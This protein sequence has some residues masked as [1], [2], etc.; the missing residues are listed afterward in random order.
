MPSMTDAACLPEP[1]CDVL[2]TTLSPRLLLP[3]AREGRVVF[4]VE[5]AC[6]VVGDVEQR[7]VLGKDRGRGRGEQQG[8]RS[9]ME[10]A[11]SAHVKPLERFVFVGE[12]L[13]RAHRTTGTNQSGNPYEEFDQARRMTSALRFLRVQAREPTSTAPLVRLL[14]GSTMIIAPAIGLAS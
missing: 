13:L 7:D 11:G 6:R 1:P 4:L 5:L 3:V 8:Q 2:T 10:V 12:A 9:A 14:A